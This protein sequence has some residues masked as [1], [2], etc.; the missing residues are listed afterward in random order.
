MILQARRDW[1]KASGTTTT[2]FIQPRPSWENGFADSF[3]GRLRDEFLNK[4]FTTAPEPQ[5]LAACWRWTSNTPKPHSVVQEPT[6]LEAVQ[7]GPG[8]VYHNSLT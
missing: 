2:A 4:L 3:M 6:P 5:I 1:S 7:Q 8:N